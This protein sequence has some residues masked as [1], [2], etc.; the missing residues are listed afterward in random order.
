M[1]FSALLIVASI[2]TAIILVQLGL[3]WRSF[4]RRTDRIIATMDRII[5]TMDRQIA[6]MK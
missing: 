4:N 3:M 5:A 6:L 2:G 1:R